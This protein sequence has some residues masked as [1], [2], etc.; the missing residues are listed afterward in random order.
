M[1]QTVGKKNAVEQKIGG[2]QQTKQNKK[3]HGRIFAV[4]EKVHSETC[5]FKQLVFTIW[6][7]WTA[8]KPQLFWP[9]LDF[10]D[11]GFL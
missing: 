1:R 2:K 5:L 7:R 6:N 10:E 9:V 8:T 4:F 3:K 11:N